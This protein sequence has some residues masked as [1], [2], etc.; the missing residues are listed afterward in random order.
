VTTTVPIVMTQTL[1]PVGS[2]FVASLARPGG[3]ITGLT[4]N[5][6]QMSGKR[7]ELLKEVV[8]HLAHLAVLDNA[9]SPGSAQALR[10]TEFA[11][12]AVGA[13]VHY[14]LV[15]RAE[16]IDGAFREAAGVGVDALQVQGSPLFILERWRLA[17]LAVQYRLPATYQTPEHVRDGGLMTYSA[18]IDDLYRRSAT[19]V[20]KILKGAKP[21]DLPVEQPTKFDL[22]IN[23]K[24]AQAIGLTI[25]PSVLQRA[26]ELIH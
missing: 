5:A 3:N 11:A 2:G 7:L 18:S 23:L 19:Y 1:D 12:R 21:G 6:P 26:T 22:V 15:R 14:W 17:D 13:Q 20:D 10:E 8:P 24:A 16:E 9:A 25:P 4:T